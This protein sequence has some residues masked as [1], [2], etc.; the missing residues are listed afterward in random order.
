ML[1]IHQ[2]LPARSPR[3]DEELHLTYEARSKSRLRCFA[4]SGEEVGLFLERG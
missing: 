3:W 2:R 4:A 1:V